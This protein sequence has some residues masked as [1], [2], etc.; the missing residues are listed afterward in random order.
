MT[1][2]GKVFVLWLPR[3]LF[4]TLLLSVLPNFSD[5]TPVV[6]GTAAGDESFYGAARAIQNTNTQ[7]GNATNGDLRY[8]N[9][10]SEIDQVFSA[11]AGNRLFVL[12]TG[13]LETNFNKL[14]IFIDAVP[15]GMNQL[16]GSNLP[17][18][19]DPFC[20]PGSS[21]STGA[22]QKLSGLRF[23]AGFEADRYVTFSNGNHQFGNP[24]NPVDIYTLSAFYADLTSG[25]G[26]QKSE[27]GF[28][29]NALGVEPGLAQGEPIDQFN[30]GC[31]GPADTSCN[32][33]EHEFAEPVDTINDPTNSRGHRDLANDIGFRMAVN[34]SNTQG[35]VPGTGP[36][37]GNPQDVLTGI[38]FS[39]PLTELGNPTGPIKIAAFINSGPHA[40]VSN[41]FAG[42]GILQGNLGGNIASIN[43]AN[44][45]GEQFVTAT[46][47]ADFD[48]DADVDQTDLTT[49]KNAYGVNS[50]GDTNGDDAS[51]G[52]DFLDW[53]RQ[54]TGT[55]DSL[56]TSALV[57]E[58]ST[59]ILLLLS[60][61]I[62]LHR[63]LNHYALSHNNTMHSRT[64]I[65]PP[66]HR[67]VL[68]ARLRNR[69]WL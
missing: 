52:V 15:G 44:I 1:D 67:H 11:I 5:A 14:E 63:R 55:L 40:F 24:S 35:V 46:L 36:T 49:W 8:A 20:C 23:D 9:G 12:I 51:N 21:P 58:P 22:L 29:R 27:I 39:I 50:S 60:M 32:P 34:N 30:N 4:S 59:T 19:V 45:T 16:I 48:R 25:P 64:I 47:P 53:Q 17:A 57:P 54:H 42:D 18:S 41:Q 37:G 61:T 38:E 10:G 6:D 33:L 28:Q 65:R 26:G 2:Q 43:L 7:F 69:R 3:V 56:A 62:R 66:R 13:N 31:S 68:V